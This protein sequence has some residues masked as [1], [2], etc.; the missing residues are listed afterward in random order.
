MR[1]LIDSDWLID[2]SR[3]MPGA[4]QT[5]DALAVEGYAVSLIT[6]GEL[7]IR[8]PTTRRIRTPP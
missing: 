3:N 2:V 6:Y 4:V 8:V 5:L 1:Y 7:C